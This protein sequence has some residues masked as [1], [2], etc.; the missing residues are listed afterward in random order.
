MANPFNY[1]LFPLTII[2]FITNE[3]VLTFYLRFLANYDLVRSGDANPFDS[4]FPLFWGI[5]G[6][7]VGLHFLTLFLKYLFLYLTLLNS[8]TSIH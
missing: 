3:I 1:F 5:L 4:N 2:T 6:M 7:M 8:N